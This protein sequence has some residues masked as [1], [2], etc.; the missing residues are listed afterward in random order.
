MVEESIKFIETLLKNFNLF[1]SESKQKEKLRE[2]YIFS[3]NLFENDKWKE[4]GD[5]DLE[6]AYHALMGGRIVKSSVARFLLGQRDPLNIL[7]NYKKG[8]FWL[9]ENRNDKKVVTSICYREDIDTKEKRNRKYKLR[10]ISFFGCSFFCAISLVP[11]ILSLIDLSFGLNLEVYI[12][13][14]VLWV[15]IAMIAVM[16]YSGI[17]SIEFAEK[18][19]NAL[20][21]NR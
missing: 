9:L 15:V 7:M 17:Q 12:L 20:D 3:K 14:C 13:L 10:L 11:L 6:L 4:M 21:E 5:S 1:N 2:D 18:V 19:I 16:Q 8:S